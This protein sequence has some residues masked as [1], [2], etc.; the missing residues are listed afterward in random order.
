MVG[1]GR[2]TVRSVDEER[3]LLAGPCTAGRCAAEEMGFV[4]NCSATT[5]IEQAF[6]ALVGCTNETC[7]EGDASDCYKNYLIVQ[8]CVWCAYVSVAV[9]VAAFEVRWN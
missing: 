5:V 7:K 1:C 8:V 6:A 3:C 2:W 9:V 4:I